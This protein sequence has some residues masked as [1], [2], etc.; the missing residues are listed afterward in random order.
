MESLLIE[1]GFN[2][3]KK[4]GILEMP[5]TLKSKKFNPLEVY[6]TKIIND[7]PESSYVFAFECVPNKS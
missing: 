5:I 2:V 4:T 6:E 7:E 1:C 3:I